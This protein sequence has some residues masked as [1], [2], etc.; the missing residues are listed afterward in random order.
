MGHRHDARL[1][2]SSCDSRRGSVALRRAECRCLLIPCQTGSRLFSWYDS[3]SKVFVPRLG[4]TLNNMPMTYLVPSG[5]ADGATQRSATL[6]EIV[7]AGRRQA[8]VIL[9]SVITTVVVAA[10]YCAFSTKVY[11]ANSKVLLDPRSFNTQNVNGDEATLLLSGVIVDSEVEVI[12][13]LNVLGPVIDKLDLTHDPEFFAPSLFDRLQERF[14]GRKTFDPETSR[15]QVFDKISKRLDVFRVNKTTY[16]IEVDFT[17]I[18]KKKAATIAN[19]IT[20]SFVQDQVYGRRQF[21]KQSSDW[22]DS[23]L[24]GLQTDA[25]KA[26]SAVQQYREKHNLVLA[27]GKLVNDQQLSDLNSQLANARISTY[28][29]Q[30]KF[31]IIETIIKTHDLNATVVESLASPVIIALRQKQLVAQKRA[32]DLTNLLGPSH[33]TVK[34]L[35]REATNYEDQIFGELGR[36][37]DSEQNDLNAARAREKSI[38]DQI[39]KLTGNSSEDN[40][41]LVALNQL[42]RVADASKT[43]YQSFL[44]KYQD[45]NQQQSVP[46]SEARVVETATPPRSPS[47]PRAIFI[48]PLAILAGLMSGIGLAMLKEHRD[49]TFR[50]GEQLRNNLGVDFLGIAPLLESESGKDASHYVSTH[51]FSR[52]ANTMRTARLAAEVNGPEKGP[53]L[54]GI[55]SASSQEGKSVIAA[56]LAMMSAHDGR[57]TLLID[58]D[59]RRCGL[60]RELAPDAKKSLADVISGSCKLADAI[61]PTALANLHILPSNPNQTVPHSSELLGSPN[62]RRFFTEQVLD[63]DYV[64]IDLPPLNALVDARAL[65]PCLTAALMVVAWGKTS[66]RSARDALSYNKDLSDCCVGAVLNAVDMKKISGYQEEAAVSYGYSVY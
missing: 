10:L 55:I 37:E 46:T 32:A 42:I 25:L 56:N 23:R 53:V 3:C 30:A 20:A 16:L 63:Y 14:F 50:N 65:A 7:A 36:I 58:A 59:L 38:S 34:L 31:G 57:K 9:R 39:V 29:A 43:L 49:K 51:P 4:S 12:K 22:L 26:D 47:W 66:I 24:V 64:V 61:L 33:I 21:A 45:L 62:A 54:L 48:I 15:T 5:A 17:S 40:R 2:A 19:A 27:D 11:T 8:P 28:Q 44:L 18:D 1:I 6:N 52:M 41:T 60:S 13:S 35:R